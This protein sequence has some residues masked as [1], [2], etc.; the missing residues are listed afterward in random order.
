MNDSNRLKIDFEEKRSGRELFIFMTEGPSFVAKQISS[1][2]GRDKKENS[3]RQ[4]RKVF[5]EVQRLTH[6]M[7]EGSEATLSDVVNTERALLL[8][9]LAYACGR[10]QIG[11]NFYTFFENLRTLKSESGL[12]N[13]AQ[14]LEAVVG[15]FTLEV[16]QQRDNN[17]RGGRGQGGPRPAHNNPRREDHRGQR[18]QHGE[19]RHQGEPKQTGNES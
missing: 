2:S 15:Y 11:N 4:L 13:F 5:E 12:K 14:F 3:K 8:A 1:D 16:E 19:R 18:P 10:K 17:D 9:R 6:G 7:S